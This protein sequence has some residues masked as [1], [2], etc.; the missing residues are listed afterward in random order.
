MSET[1]RLWETGC[2]VCRSRSRR[3]RLEH[4]W[5]TCRFETNATETVREGMSFIEDMRAPL[6]RQG[7]R[8]CAGGTDRRCR[9]EGRQGG[10][11][12]GDVVRVAVGAL[13]FGNAEVREWVEEQN[14]FS[15]SIEEGND[16]W[17]ALMKYYQIK[18]CTTKRDKPGWT[19]FWRCG[20]YEQQIRW[21]EREWSDKE[22][23]PVA[24]LYRCPYN[25]SF[26]AQQTHR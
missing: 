1:V 7:F 3:S 8:C 15:N 23:N 17:A 24:N 19:S 11:S 13:I 14:M 20:R 6:R 10:C 22:V 5:E 16:E 12:G 2:I 26:E 21:Q 18:G 4:A 25:S 9:A